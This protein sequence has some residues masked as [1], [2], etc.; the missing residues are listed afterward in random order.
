[1]LIKKLLPFLL[2]FVLPLA[3]IYAWWG[4]FSPV[5][6]TEEVRGPHVYAYLEHSGDYSKLPELTEEARDLLKASRV[7]PGLSLT[8]LF[9]NPDLVN[10]GERRAHAGFL[11]PEGAQVRAPLKIG[12]IPARRVALARVQAGPLLAPS[13]AYPA[14]DRWSQSRGRGITMPTV[15][16]FEPSGTPLRMGVL[17]VEMPMP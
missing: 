2:A 10:V 15:E 16:I 7:T 1:M 13:R 8:V 12:H 9:S 4:G 14:L 11:V 17:Y 6:I 5:A 3:A